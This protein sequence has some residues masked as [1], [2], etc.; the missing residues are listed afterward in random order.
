MDEGLSMGPRTRGTRGP[1][2]SDRPPLF[3]GGI[4]EIICIGR[5]SG[6]DF[7]EM[8][9]FRDF[10]FPPMKQT[11]LHGWGTQRF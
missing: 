3:N 6:L 8:R 5:S 4:D 9:R 2:M 1:D 7:G 11:A 10:A